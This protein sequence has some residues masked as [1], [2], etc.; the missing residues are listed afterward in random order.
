MSYSKVGMSHLALYCTTLAMV[1]AFVL[2]NIIDCHTKSVYRSM[3]LQASVFTIQLNFD[4]NL[5]H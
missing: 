5:L 2:T 1:V 4:Q 3:V